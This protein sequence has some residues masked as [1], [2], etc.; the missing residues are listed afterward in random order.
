[1]PVTPTDEEQTYEQKIS[2]V[3][4]RFAPLSPEARHRLMTAYDAIEVTETEDDS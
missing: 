2:D 1:M 4:Q 3:M